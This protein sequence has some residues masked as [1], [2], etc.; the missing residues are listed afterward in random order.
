MREAMGDP[1]RNDDLERLKYAL[2]EAA[3]ALADAE[4][5]NNK[6]T[7]TMIVTQMDVDSA[8][9]AFN[10]AKNTYNAARWGA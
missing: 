3:L 9:R 2:A 5:K 10:A 6:A 1:F 4:A 7:A 8:R